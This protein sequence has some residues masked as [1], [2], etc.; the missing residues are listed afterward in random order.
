MAARLI[1][2]LTLVLCARPALLGAQADPPFRLSDPDGQ[3]LVLET[4]DVR[5]AVHG[6]LSLTELELVFRNPQQR[7]IEGRFT[8]VLPAGATVSRFAKEVNGRLME[9]EV[10]ERLRAQ[11]VYE[12]I[13]HQMRDPALLEQDRG[14]RFS[15]RVFPIEAGQ[16]VRLV[17]GYS[18]LLPLAE[19][20]RTY[21]LPLR[22]LPRLGLLRVE[23]LLET[24]PGERLIHEAAGASSPTG[25]GAA[26]TV[27]FSNE[28]F[29][30]TED[31]E[32]R[33]SPLGD[34]APTRLLSAGDFYIASF[35]PDVPPPPVSAPSRWVFAVDL[36]ASGAEGMEHR[37]A[38]LESLFGSLPAT[39]SV[40]LYLFDRSVVPAGSHAAGTLARTIAGILRERRF[41]GST[42]LHLAISLLA[43]RSRGPARERRFR[44]E[45]RQRP[46][47]ARRERSR[48]RSPPRR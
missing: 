23:G 39:D 47:A 42:D 30:P 40:S 31:L 13:L 37:I 9:G 24:L 36:S 1:L 27:R 6:M 33:W 26:R 17:L 15:V 16:R 44:H 4:L 21:R 34:F 29:V 2:L 12:Q 35:R 14:N 32:Y 18:T 20:S 41:L 46:P 11:Q 8:A 22:G 48:R 45:C 28:S 10:V 3:D 25:D 38:A 43:E 19:G 5:F 7:R